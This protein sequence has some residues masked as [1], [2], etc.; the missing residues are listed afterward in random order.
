MHEDALPELVVEDHELAFVVKKGLPVLAFEAC[1]ERIF[2]AHD[3]A[4][5]AP[6]CRGR[7]I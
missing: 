4:H 7:L 1:V 2:H 6:A 3:A 5:P